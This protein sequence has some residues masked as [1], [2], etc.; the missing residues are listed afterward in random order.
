MIQ[1]LISFT[2]ILCVSFTGFWFLTQ[3]WIQ[4]ST[5]PSI[6]CPTVIHSKNQILSIM[7]ISFVKICWNTGYA[8]PLKH[9]TGRHFYRMESPNIQFS[10]L[11]PSLKA[12]AVAPRPSNCLPVKLWFPEIFQPSFPKSYN[13]HPYEKLIFPNSL[14]SLRVLFLL[15]ESVSIGWNFQ[16]IN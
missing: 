9:G 13:T 15:Y 1:N 10:D 14:C 11:Y 12:A 2:L 8:P 7:F 5:Y 3:I 4:N 6:K 16:R